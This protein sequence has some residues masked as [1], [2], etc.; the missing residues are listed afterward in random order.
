MRNAKLALGS[1]GLLVAALASPESASSRV[2]VRIPVVSQIAVMAST[3]SPTPVQVGSSGRMRALRSGAPGS[4]SPLT[5]DGRLGTDDAIALSSPLAFQVAVRATCPSRAT[6]CGEARLSMTETRMASFGQGMPR[7][8]DAMA[9]VGTDGEVKLA[10]I[11]TR[12][13]TLGFGLSA[14]SITVSGP[15]EGASEP[16]EIEVTTSPVL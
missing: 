13:M 3:S 4:A 7:G 6:G 10:D 9:R 12:P 1:M 16:I 2:S 5:I 14:C 15:H 8:L 11:T